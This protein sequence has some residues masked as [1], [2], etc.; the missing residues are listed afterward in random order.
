[1]SDGSTA[2][3]FLT[4]PLHRERQRDTVAR[5]PSG[6][7]AVTATRPI[8]AVPDHAVNRLR[9]ASL[10]GRL[11]RLARRGALNV[12]F[13]SARQARSCA[14][15]YTWGKLPLW[16]R[17]P[18]FVVELDNPY[19][20][21]LYGKIG[22]VRR[23]ILRRILLGD[24]CAGLVCISQACRASTA[25]VLGADVAEQARVVYPYVGRRSQASP[26]H[27]ET[28]EAIFVGS[29]FWLK[30]GFELC[31]AFASVASKLPG[32]RLT[33]IANV[34]AAVR[35]RFACVPIEF[36][37]AR[38]ERADVAGRLARADLFVM[39]TLVESFGMAALEALA[40]GL[41]L[42]T[43]AV[44]A[45]PEIVHDG[46]NGVILPD[47]FGYWR[48]HEANRAIWRHHDLEAYVRGRRFPALEAQLGESL[49]ML[50]SDRDRLRSMGAASKALFDARFSPEVHAASFAGA[51]NAF[52]AGETG[53]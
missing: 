28:L 10:R 44:Y 49:R 41:P 17:R 8:E 53:R 26:G 52:L 1:M 15:R 36:L 9:M 51:M 18:P 38:L 46:V 13:A 30:G 39:P 20:L 48:D 47:C 4:H 31:C 43:T 5:L 12:S 23:T 14:M 3:F 29:Q 32:A 27:G 2:I 6:F 24:R 45:L 34:Q 7:R 22:P 40:H 11:A 33:V 35:A 25:A 42:L 16:P 19:V 37:P 21:A 50:L